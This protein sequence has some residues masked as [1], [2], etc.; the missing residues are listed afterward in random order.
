MSPIR[1]MSCFF[2]LPMLECTSFAFKA[3]NSPE[4]RLS[5]LSKTIR[6]TG[7]ASSSTIGA[8]DAIPQTSTPEFKQIMKRVPKSSKDGEDDAKSESSQSQL[9]SHEERQA[10]YE[11][12]RARIFSDY[13]DGQGV[14]P[15]EKESDAGSESMTSNADHR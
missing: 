5:E 15:V 9:L 2:D 10:V 7:S 11:K 13:V 3:D 6:T 8:E 14:E 1:V 12:A 4:S